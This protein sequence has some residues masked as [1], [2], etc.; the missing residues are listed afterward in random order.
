MAGI[1]SS[2]FLFPNFLGRTVLSITIAVFGR[3]P[4]LSS[5]K[6]RIPHNMAITKCTN[7]L[8]GIYFRKILIFPQILFWFFFSSFHLTCTILGDPWQIETIV[9]IKYMPII[10][11]VG[12]FCLIK[13][14]T[15]RESVPTFFRFLFLNYILLSCL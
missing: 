6:P 14:E 15:K 7:P 2:Q 10:S 1:Y 11:A 4:S 8:R 13:L 9:P 3:S 12:F 5:E